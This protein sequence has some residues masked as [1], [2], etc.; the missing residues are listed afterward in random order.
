MI[1][2]LQPDAVR[3]T[4]T[5]NTIEKLA[6]GRGRPSTAVG[7]DQTTGTAGG[8][9]GEGRGVTACGRFQGRQIGSARQKERV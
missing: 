7:F 6:R 4:Y 2:P 8:A 9:V 5:S 1:S 3:P